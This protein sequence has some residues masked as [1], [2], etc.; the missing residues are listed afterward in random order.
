MSSQNNNGHSETSHL[1]GNGF[2][3]INDSNGGLTMKTNLKSLT[4]LDTGTPSSP[5][6]SSSLKRN[7]S[8]GNLMP[9]E[10][11][12]TRVRVLYTGGTIGMVRNER[13]GKFL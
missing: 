1:D 13:N 7:T 4:S 3:P 5:T 12:E 8:Y 10:T 6:K 11:K 9:A 2:A